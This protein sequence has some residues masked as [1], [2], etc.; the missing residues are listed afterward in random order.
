MGFNNGFERKKFEAK[1]KELKKQYAAAGMSEAAIQEM[2]EYDLKVFNRTRADR[3]HEQPIVGICSDNNEEENLTKSTRLQDLANSLV[4]TDT[5]STQPKRFRW[6]DEISNEKLYSIIVDLPERDKEF[7]TYL[8]E[9]YTREEIA[10]M[11]GIKVQSVNKKIAKFKNLLA[12]A[13]SNSTTA[14][15]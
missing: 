13:V 15:I 14:N 3:E 9:G 6:I 2:Y 4:V 7:L 10:K 8:V 11:R 1:W 5:Y 12:E